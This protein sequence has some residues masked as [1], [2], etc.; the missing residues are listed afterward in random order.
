[1]RFRA[2]PCGREE[3]ARVPAG[4]PSPWSGIWLLF[5]AVQVDVLVEPSVP[6]LDL[7]WALAWRP[8]PDDGD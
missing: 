2:K 4:V 6:K 7:F 8:E 1:M 5:L 3:P